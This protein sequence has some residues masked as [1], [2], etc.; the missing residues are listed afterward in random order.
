VTPSRR[1]LVGLVAGIGAGL[2][3][4]E[5][6]G[7]LPIIA[8]GFVKLLQMT[9]LPYLAVSLVKSLGGL[10]LEDARRLGVRA[11]AVMVVLWAVGL[12]FAFSMA[13]ALPRVATGAFFSTS[14]LAPPATFD[15]VELY[16]PSNPFHAL[17]NGVI[18]AVV[19][20]LVV[21]AIALVGVERKEALLAP[22][23]VAA[24]AIAR[25]TR[26]VVGLTPYGLFA[27]AATAV[28]TLDFEQLSTIRIYI[29][30]YVAV[31]LLVA[32]WVLPGLIWALTAIPYRD[33]LG[34]ARDELVTAFVA[35]DYFIVLPGLMA[36][37]RETLVR[38]SPKDE[39]I[40]QL[41]D[42]IVPTSFNFPHVGKLLSLSFVLFAGWLSHNP[43]P[44]TQY[45]QLALT[46]LLSFFGSLNAA[47]PFLLD[48][49]RIPA[50]TFNLFL[51]TAV[52]N[53]RF[54]TLVAAVH[55]LTVA[56]LGSAA[57]TGALHFNLWRLV[58]YAAITAALSIATIGGLNVVLT[59]RF[60]A[61]LQGDAIVYG[62]T[63]LLVQERATLVSSVWPPE[64]QP[65]PPRVLESIRSRGVLRV[66]AVSTEPP[67][68]FVNRSGNF[69]G[70]DVS[71]SQLLARDVGVPVEF[72][73]TTYRD[74]LALLE[75]GTCDLA[76][77]GI[78][79]TPLRS[80][81]ALYSEPYLD[82][83]AAFLVRD[84]VRARFEAWDGIA[85]I[86]DL[87]I[88]AP[89]LP[90]YINE[91]RILAPGLPFTTLS[92]SGTTLEQIEPFDAVLWAAERGSVM[93]LLDP[94][95]AVVIPRPGLIK[96]PIALPLARHDAEWAMFVNTW[97]GMKRR[98]ETLDQLYKHWILGQTVTGKGERWSILHNVL[99]W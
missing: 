21:F 68:S 30:T 33:I 48:V 52:I 51:A 8:D 32:L 61:R 19:L 64:S 95:W 77:G 80:L 54:G 78:P 91:L 15:F 60:A 66:A 98:D 53:S 79:L 9:V 20:F 24:E 3:F 96:I 57:V 41:P 88:G 82:E 83:T 25:A 35:A 7:P 86:R 85:A 62:M 4:G 46:G 10:T 17:A 75:A 72:V 65:R 58:R 67:Y 81:E 45:P 92:G 2:F 13:L 50:D 87:R 14:T 71:M 31:A 84:H 6:L 93:T 47:V 38:H 11:G 56:I 37:T 59:A 42:V 44:V 89:N 90:Y 29:V 99:G 94:R 49:F 16:I 74:A 28:G 23:A 26:F 27:V 43:V 22:L 12:S 40:A 55:T 36:A 70:F 69:V 39:R 5:R 76:V 1:I 34:R 73:Q 18:P 63:P 97:I